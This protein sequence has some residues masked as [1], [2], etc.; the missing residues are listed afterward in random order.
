MRTLLL[1]LAIICISLTA[2]SQ[3]RGHKN[4]IFF[5]FQPEDNGIGLRYDHRFDKI[6]V[7]SSFSKGDYYFSDAFRGKGHIKDHY[8]TAIGASCMSSH[9][10]SI[11]L[12]VSYHKYGE[13]SLE[14]LYF[15]LNDKVFNPF[16][17]EFG[18]YALL[19][20][21]SAGLRS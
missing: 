7:Y 18:V 1:T 11:T 9:G 3:D 4:T 20:R 15:D 10:T 8:K 5:T 13:K 14:H 2:N 17:A 12:G 21:L 19:G 16:S 6:G